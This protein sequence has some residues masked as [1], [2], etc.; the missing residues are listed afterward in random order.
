MGPMIPT[1]TPFRAVLA[2]AEWRELSVENTDLLM[3][4]L[5]VIDGE[6]ISAAA[7]KAKAQ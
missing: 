1:P 2:W 5:R 7:A 4:G 3:E 6:Y